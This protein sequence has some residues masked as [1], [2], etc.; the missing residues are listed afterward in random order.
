MRVPR[1]SVQSAERFPPNTSSLANALSASSTRS[2]FTSSTRCST[3]ETIP[4]SRTL[5]CANGGCVNVPRQSAATVWF[6]AYLCWLSLSPAVFPRT[7]ASIVAPC[8]NPSPDRLY[9]VSPTVP[10]V[11][12]G[13]D[14]IDELHVSRPC[15]SRTVSMYR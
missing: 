6:V 3:F 9:L 10:P 4:P 7:L 1:N 13:E 5:V 11:A 15:L 12:W 14:G 2:T 8:P